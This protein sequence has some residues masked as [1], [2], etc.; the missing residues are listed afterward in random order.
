MDTKL[1]QQMQDW[2][3]AKP[4][5]RS[6]EAG[7]EMVLK[8]TGNRFM[9]QNIANRKDFKMVEYQLRKYLPF[10]L[11]QITHE[12][13]EAMKQQCETI[14]EEH[15]LEKSRK[16]VETEAEELKKGKRQDHNDLPQ[17]IQALYVENLNL[18][19]K[20]RQLHL[21]A[22][23]ATKSASSCPDGDIYPFVKELI[24]LDKLYHENWAKYDEYGRETESDKG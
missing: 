20:M 11:Q 22:R 17:E 4:E 10:R 8:L 1:T 12:E 13:V 23:M 6:L 5:N 18:L 14:A 16:P 3:E 24:R 21:Q 2:L 9:V 7:A 19:H 15:H